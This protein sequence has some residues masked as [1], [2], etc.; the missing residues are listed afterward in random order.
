MP[1]TV[2]HGPHMGVL[3]RAALVGGQNQYLDQLRQ[4]QEQR[5]DRDRL[6]QYDVMRDAMRNRSY[7][8]SQALRNRGMMQRNLLDARTRQDFYRQQFQNQ[9]EA[10]NREQQFKRE[11]SQEEYDAEIRERD[12]VGQALVK[13]RQGGMIDDAEFQRLTLENETGKQGIRVRPP[14]PLGEK[15]KTD[16]VERPDLGLVFYPDK[17]GNGYESRPITAAPQQ[18]PFE[19]DV[20]Q[21]SQPVPG[22]LLVR[23]PDGKLDYLKFETPESAEASRSMEL[24]E[25]IMEHATKLYTAAGRNPE[26][27]AA[28]MEFEDAVD[29]A[30]EILGGGAGT[31]GPETGGFRPHLKNPNM[32]TQRLS[33][34]MPGWMG[35]VARQGFGHFLVYMHEGQFLPVITNPVEYAA[36]PSG[37]AFIGV[38][39]DGTAR[40]RV[41]P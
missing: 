37:T 24:R 26:T 5:Y 23:Q 16:L 7:L 3:G 17:T 34:T 4:R 40:R 38:D 20:A 35:Q 19:Q 6:A 14:V 10:M 41:K 9:M 18:V 32:G 29:K 28:N 2:E 22:G 8:Q 30:R 36:I 21:R 12:R 39:G 13:A 15:L 33:P 27:G 25:S 1:I 11:L 31:Q